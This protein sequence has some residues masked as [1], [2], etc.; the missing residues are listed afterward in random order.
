MRGT[1]CFAGYLA[2]FYCPSTSEIWPSKKGLIREVHFKKCA[3]SAAI[4]F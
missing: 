4:K 3:D 2:V 1:A